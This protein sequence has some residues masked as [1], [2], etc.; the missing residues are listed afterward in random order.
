MFR[1]HIVCLVVLSFTMLKSQ[2]TFSAFGGTNDEIGYDVVVDEDG[3]LLILTADRT[4]TKGSEDICLIRVN[5]DRRITGRSCFG[6]ERQDYPYS[7]EHTS[8]GGLVISGTRWKG[9]RDAY[10]LK[11]D[12]D[13]ATEW[14]TFYDGGARHH[15]EGF[16]AVE[17][18]DGG[19]LLSGMTGSS[20]GVTRGSMLLLKLAA[21][22]EQEWVVHQEVTTKNFLFDVI[23][24]S[25]GDFVSAGVE[26]GHHRYSE[27]EFYAP[28][29][30]AVVYKHDNQGNELWRTYLGGQE[31]DWITKV[32]QSPTGGYY[33][34]GSTQSAGAG[35][36]DLYLVKMDHN[37]VVEWEKTY[38]DFQFDYGRDIEILDNGD[39][40]L[41]GT[42]CL[43][44]KDFT[45]DVLLVRVD[46]EGEFL[47]QE[48]FGG[49]GNEDALGMTLDQGFVHIVG[50]VSDKNARDKDV[51]L[52]DV[53]LSIS[54]D[55]D[56]NYAEPSRVLVYPNPIKSLVTFDLSKMPCGEYRLNIFNQQGMLLASYSDHENYLL[57]VDTDSWPS[58]SY[59]YTITSGCYGVATGKVIKSF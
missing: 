24:D 16:V 3:S 43:D 11:L 31:N 20:R 4:V 12:R 52:L 38:G 27:F 14:E 46:H 22:G 32:V 42:T 7:L 6:T 9:R 33:L 57:K 56:N 13:F 47:W 35:S 18:R 21:N 28:S 10:V 30:T 2:E 39:L 26:S 8:D 41:L 17:T 36:F 48:V 25:Q 23:E 34:L 58:S 19:Y 37:G 1:L 51:L 15:D 40:L 59:F 55:V 5:G 44:A 54:V 49:A 45:T 50:E 53:P 29:A